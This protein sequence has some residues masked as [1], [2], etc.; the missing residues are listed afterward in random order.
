MESIFAFSAGQN[1]LIP[2]TISISFVWVYFKPKDNATFVENKQTDYIS[3]KNAIF[4]LA[5]NAYANH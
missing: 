5:R 1:H 3:V 2:A 4:M